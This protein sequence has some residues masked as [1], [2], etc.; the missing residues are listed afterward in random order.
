MNPGDRVTYVSPSG[1]LEHGIVK[2]EAKD[3]S[4]FVVYNCGGEWDRYQDFT[5][6]LTSTEDLVPGWRG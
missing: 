4:V 5:G 6:Q 1:R 2:S 3:G